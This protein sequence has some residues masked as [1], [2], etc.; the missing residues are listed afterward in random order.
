MRCLPRARGT[1][2]LGAAPQHRPARTLGVS[3]VLTRPPLVVLVSRMG[4]LRLQWAKRMARGLWG[5][6]WGPKPKPVVL[7]VP[8]R[9][10][11]SCLIHPGLPG[12]PPG[13]HQ[14]RAMR[15][16][17]P[18]SGQALTL[19]RHV[20]R[21]HFIIVPWCSTLL[22]VKRGRCGVSLQRRR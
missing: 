4:T 19:H 13:L 18:A 22:V 7:S 15:V 14:G 3:R 11:C 2:E 6:E 17:P 21:S 12:G 1:P 16:T 20:P 9:Q 10:Q 5:L 8:R